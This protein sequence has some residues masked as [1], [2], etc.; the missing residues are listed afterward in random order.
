M[1]ATA[2]P[3]AT[4][5][6]ATAV[7]TCIL[8]ALAGLMFGLDVGVISGAQQFIQKD[9]AI[10][11]HTI[12][13]VVSSMMAGAA[14]GALGAAWMSSALGR[15]R[16]LIIGA[17]LF[18]IGSILCGTA[19]SPAILIVGRIVLG[20]AIGIASFTAP[21]YLAEIAPEKIRGAMISLY[22]LMIT[23]GILVAFLSDTAFSYTGNWRW[24]LGVIAIPGVL[25]L[26]GVVF[27]PCSPRWLMMR[28]QHEEAER[29]LHKL[30]A[31]KDAVALELAEIT[32]QLK[33]P[34]RGFHLFFQNRNFR[35]SVGLGIVLQV[36][37]QLTG[38]NV[39]MYYAPRIFQGM[40]YNT[41]SQLWFTAIVGL[42]NVLATFIAIAFVDKLGRKPILYA[43]FVVMTIGLG[44]VGTM[45]H[46]GIHTHAE[47]LFTVGMLLIFIIGFAMS[48]GP[49][50]WTVCSEIQPLKGRDFGI[51]CS[52]ITNWVANMI[53]GG[54]FLSLLNGIGDAGTFWLYAAFNAVF[55][56]LT[57]WLVPE[58]KNISLE[59][60][61]RNLMAGK[62]LRRIGQ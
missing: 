11:D 24:M 9:F 39:V 23:I 46:L 58:T 8:A 28:G 57:F 59:H 31:D 44:I 54:T 10:S 61:E 12:E 20:V 15:K 5:S 51:G 56:L 3:A 18:V 40:G 41:E 4:H 35:R 47:Q 2:P 21:L 62:P 22:Q 1:N 50:I 30:R 37:Q 38:M 14:L 42:T 16:S 45:M 49:L 19:G 53:V 33:V 26:F 27:L 13:W 52:T 29:V 7:F 17:V 43:G 34:Q 32:E 25:F 60:I 6:K 36:M 55:I 48:A